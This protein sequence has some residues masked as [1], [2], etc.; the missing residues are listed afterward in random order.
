[1]LVTIKHSY[2]TREDPVTQL[3]QATLQTDRIVD[4]EQLC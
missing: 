2:Q 4:P 1:M 3:G